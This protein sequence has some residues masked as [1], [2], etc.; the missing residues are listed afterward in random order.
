M[1]MLR[2]VALISALVLAIPIVN[3]EEEKGEKETPGA[4]K[5]RIDTEHLFGFMLGTDIGE[6]GEKEIQP[7]ILSRSEKG[8]GSYHVFSP[9]IEYEFVPIENLRLSPGVSLA[10]Y[11]IAGVPDREKAG[12]GFAIDAEPSLSRVDETSGEQIQG[13]GADISVIFDKEWVPNQVMSAFNVVYSPDTSRSKATGFGVET[14][15]HPSD[16]QLVAYAR[17]YFNATDR[18][19]PQKP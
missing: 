14:V 11:H 2:A 9:Q 18:M 5:E 12:F 15:D 10:H 1:A 16:A 6:V 4:E 13:Y 3:A 8:L 17:K 19:Q 7:V